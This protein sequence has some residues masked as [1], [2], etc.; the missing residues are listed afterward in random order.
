MLVNRL[1]LNLRQEGTDTGA[2]VPSH[3]LSRISFGIGS[4]PLGNIGAP[5]S[6][7]GDE[8]DNVDSSDA[9]DE[10]RNG[11]SVLTDPANDGNVKIGQ[12]RLSSGLLK[13]AFSDRA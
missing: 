11:N 7:P 4:V 6:H 3:T 9:H 1:V 10:M 12:R 2:T 8:D 5:L 13:D